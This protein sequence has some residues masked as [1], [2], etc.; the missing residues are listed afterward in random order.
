MTIRPID[1]M[2]DNELFAWIRDTCIET[3]I[4]DPDPLIIV[5][6]A[7]TLRAKHE[8]VIL[9]NNEV[10]RLMALLDVAVDGVRKGDGDTALMAM[11]EALVTAERLPKKK[12]S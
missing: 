1:R 2:T 7:Q 10:D 5:G 9:V 8:Q 3:G 12:I 11:Q 6:I 4:A